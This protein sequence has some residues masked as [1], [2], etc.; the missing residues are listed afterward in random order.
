MSIEIRQ[1]VIKSNVLQPFGED[2][3]QLIVE[4]REAIKQDVLAECRRLVQE[5]LRER[6]DR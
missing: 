4:D 2:E 5:M 3:P 6:G 1:L